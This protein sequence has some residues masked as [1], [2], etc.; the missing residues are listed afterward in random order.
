MK[1]SSQL[2][3]LGR[4]S[5]VTTGVYSASAPSLRVV[6]ASL[7][8]SRNRPLD[9]PSVPWLRWQVPVPP[10]PFRVAVLMFA[11]IAGSA[12][13]AIATP[14]AK[15]PTRQPSAQEPQLAA[16]VLGPDLGELS[17]SEQAAVHPFLEAAQA[18][19]E[20]APA[21]DGNDRAAAERADAL[22]RR[23]HELARQFVRTL[24]AEARLVAMQTEAIEL[25]KRVATARALLEETL[26]RVGRA[27]SALQR[28][29]ARNTESLR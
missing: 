1:Y 22:S 10:S 25:E 4:P 20:A 8:D 17:P 27:R 23:W 28:E 18:A 9:L 19:R 14:A 13:V 11:G 12:H 24:R 3:R 21:R 7:V 6:W 2:A 16:A 5:V 15:T 29:E 26:A